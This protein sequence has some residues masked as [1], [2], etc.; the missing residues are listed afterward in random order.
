MVAGLQHDVSLSKLKLLELERAVSVS[1]RRLHYHASMTGLP[2][3]QNAD[4][5]TILSQSQN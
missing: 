4:L 5:Q 1:F 3:K 2:M